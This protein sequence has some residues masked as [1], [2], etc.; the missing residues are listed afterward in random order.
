MKAALFAAGALAALLAI[1]SPVEAQIVKGRV[2]MAGTQTPLVDVSV[3]LRAA[4]GR[5]LASALTNDAGEFR[6]HSSRITEATILA[7]RIG[8]QPITTSAVQVA[9][10]QVIDVQIEM[11]ETA[12]PLDPLTVRA[13]EHFDIGPL[14]GYF[15]RVQRHE[16]MGFGHVLTRDQVQ[17]RDAI[18]VADLLR[19]VPRIAVVQAPGRGQHVMFRGG[20]QG[21]CTPRVYIN[22]VYANRNSLAYIDELVR[23]S[24]LEGIEIYRGLAEMPGE[25]YDDSHCGVILIWTRRDA[26][27][28]R[29]F[30]WKRVL[31]TIGGIAAVSFVLFR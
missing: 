29:P 16:R 13:R 21:Q 10:S 2:V 17:E 14:S 6:L 24:E 20:A 11:S 8:L 25:F 1:G 26:E 22:G 31:L 18:D 19:E 5:I 15:E 3:K 7:E 30:A 28:G 27:G 4:D 23:P 12:V 9:L